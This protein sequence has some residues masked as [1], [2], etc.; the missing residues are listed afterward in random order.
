[1][2]VNLSRVSGCGTADIEAMCDLAEA[3]VKAYNL[4]PWPEPV[5]RN[6]LALA[7]SGGTPDPV[8]AL[9]LFEEWAGLP[10]G[11]VGEWLQDH[12][13]QAVISRRELLFW[14]G[15]LL[16]VFCNPA[17]Y[18]VY[19]EGEAGSTPESIREE[20]AS[21]TALHAE[22]LPAFIVQR[23]GLREAALPGGVLEGCAMTLQEAM[24]RP[25]KGGGR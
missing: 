22:V 18:W 3:E 11:T 17:L 10:E 19:L 14:P 15:G 24:D 12:R 20:V 7:K 4:P 25:Q 6:Y 5:T 16:G 1:M 13:I 2:M 23:L 9:L 8:D 21:A